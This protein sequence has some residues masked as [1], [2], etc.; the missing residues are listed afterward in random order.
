M[1]NDYSEFYIKGV[2]D[3]DNKELINF[4]NY[5]FGYDESIKYN[6][7]LNT[8]F[9]KKDYVNSDFDRLLPFSSIPKNG[10]QLKKTFFNRKSNVFEIH[11]FIEEDTEHLMDLIDTF[12]KL[13]KNNEKE[14]ICC[15][16]YVNSF[17]LP[18]MIN[19]KENTVEEYLIEDDNTVTKYKE[20][21]NNFLN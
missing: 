20:L 2:I 14:H 17:I 8:D 15:L 18:K 13:I 5:L 4:V 3:N 6:S 21:W 7:I 19:I 1:H 10:T 9:F 11:S 12:S 16:Y